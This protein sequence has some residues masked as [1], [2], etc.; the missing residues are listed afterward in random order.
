VQSNSAARFCPFLF[1]FTVPVS[2]LVS[3]ADVCSG[4]NASQVTIYMFPFE[5]LEVYK[6]AFEQN[7]GF[8]GF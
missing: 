6:K 3:F 1:L 5:N 2:I 7:G 8:T 4:V